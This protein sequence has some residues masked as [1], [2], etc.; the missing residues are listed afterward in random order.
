MLFIAHHLAV[1]R[2]LSHRGFGG[3]PR[4]LSSVR[5]APR[6]QRRGVSRSLRLDAR[7]FK[8]RKCQSPSLLA[9]NQCATTNCSRVSIR[10][11]P[12]LTGAIHPRPSC[13]RPLVV[14]SPNRPTR[15]TCP[16]C[17]IIGGA[18]VSPGRCCP[19]PARS[20]GGSPC[21]VSIKCQRACSLVPPVR[22]APR[23][24]RRG[25]TAL[26]VLMR[27]SSIRAKPIPFPTGTKPMCYDIS[28]G[29][30]PARRER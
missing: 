18:G 26:S 2:L 12:T 28:A 5:P 10:P 25:I 13:C 20:R 30:R 7:F 22:P 15:P 17:P 16:T 3:I 11:R 19:A 23:R 24:Q 8:S 9:P 6:R 1:A 29:R 21:P 4:S 27:D 14:L